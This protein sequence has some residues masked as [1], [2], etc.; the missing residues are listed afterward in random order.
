VQIA[1]GRVHVFKTAR[2]RDMLMGNFEPKGPV[3]VGIKD[4]GLALD[5]TKQLG[6][7][8]PM[9]GLYHQLLLKAHYNGWDQSDATVVMKIY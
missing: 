8:L 1:A 5:S 3:W 2:G 9:T 7:T 6:V 4:V